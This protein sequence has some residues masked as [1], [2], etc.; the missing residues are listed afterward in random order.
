MKLLATKPFDKDFE[1][2]PTRIKT[3]ALK[4][5]N[6]LLQ[7]PRHPSLRIKKMEDPRDIWEGSITK[8]YRFTFQIEGDT[9]RLRRIGTHEI[10]KTP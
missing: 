7:N 8:S 1:E 2:L 10:L 6:I 9:Y 5:F 4:K 3:L